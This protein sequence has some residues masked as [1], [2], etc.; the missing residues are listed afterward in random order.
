MNKFQKRK[1]VLR[2]QLIGAKYT[3]ALVAMEFAEKHHTGTRKDGVTPEFDHQVSIA[4]YALTLPFMRFR[5]EIIAT[6]FL[7]DVRED[8]GITHAEIVALF[9][10]DPAKGERIAQAVDRM[11]KTFRGQV[12]D[13]TDLFALMAADPIASIAKGCDRI[14]NLQSM[15]GVF[16]PEKQQSYVEEARAL[17]LPMLKTAR[18]NFAYQVHAYENIKFVL[19]SQMELIEASLEARKEA[20]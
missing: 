11:T 16:S 13:E 17:F 9:P 6:I 7:H 3:D 14:H 4:L 2:Q 10:E 12:R 8:Y 20:A 19:V 15:V 5:E 18:R 1:L